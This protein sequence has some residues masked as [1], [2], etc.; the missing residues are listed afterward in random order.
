[1]AQVDRSLTLVEPFMF[2]FFALV[3][4]VQGQ[5]GQCTDDDAKKMNIEF[6]CFSTQCAKTNQF[7][8]QPGNTDWTNFAG[9][10]K[11]ITDKEK[12]SSGC[13]NCM[14]HVYL[15]IAEQCTLDCAENLSY[16]EYCPVCVHEKCGDL[17][18]TCTGQP[19]APLCIQEPQSQCNDDD[20]KK[21]NTVEFSCSAANCA[22]S[23][24][25]GLHGTSKCIAEKEEISTGCASCI[26]QVAE[27]TAMDCFDTPQGANFGCD[28]KDPFSDGCQACAH[29]TT[30]NLALTCTGQP[31][32]PDAQNCGSS[33]A[34]LV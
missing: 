27:R 32:A 1:L 28:K 19:L 14:G 33:D 15:C 16:D 12:V 34:I 10:A 7:A 23:N 4:A 21:L 18:K 17:A 5:A 2:V 11:C 3:A 9:T 13:A 26:G 22:K 20:A 25:F 29:H 30:D 8:Y 6:S 24:L 31:L